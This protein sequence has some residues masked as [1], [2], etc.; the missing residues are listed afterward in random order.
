MYQ[1]KAIDTPASPQAIRAQVARIVSSEGF[2]RSRRMQRFLEF[3][4]EETLAGRAEELGEYGI[5]T[6]V[7]DRSADFEPAVD[8]VVRIEAR[9]LRAKLLEYYGTPESQQGDQV[10]IEVPKGAYVPV[11]RATPP[12]QVRGVPSGESPRRLAVLPFEVLS[13][14]P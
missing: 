2:A 7:F 11:F 6:A 5:A 4:V 12:V 9:R 3:I 10:L 1:P 8:P 13:A 14:A